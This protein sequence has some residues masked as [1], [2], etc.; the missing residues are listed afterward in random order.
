M[1]LMVLGALHGLQAW[2]GS[3]VARAK[4]ERG[5]TLVEYGLLVALIAVVVMATLSVLGVRVN[6]MFCEVVRRLGGTC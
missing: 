1:T 5:A 6:F 2:V 3:R 4:E